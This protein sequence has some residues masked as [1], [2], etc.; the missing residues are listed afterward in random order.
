MI[1]YYSII[2]LL[3]LVLSKIHLEKRIILCNVII[4]LSLLFISHLL[5]K[6]VPLAGV[7][8]VNL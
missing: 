8:T 2:L 6:F 7:D 3:S 5:K 1:Y 4:F